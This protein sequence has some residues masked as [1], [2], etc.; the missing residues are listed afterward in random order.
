MREVENTEKSL[1]NPSVNEVKEDP[2]QV[3]EK[4]EKLGSSLDSMSI[5]DGTTKKEGTLENK[6][7][8][9]DDVKVSDVNSKATQQRS[10]A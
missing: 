4:K 1:D 3:E 9:T 6:E 8:K 5:K 2:K 7:K 10:S